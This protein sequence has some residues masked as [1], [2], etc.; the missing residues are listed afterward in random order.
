[1]ARWMIL[2]E[3]V[4]AGAIAGYDRAMIGSCRD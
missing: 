2:F 4:W 3:K 1:L